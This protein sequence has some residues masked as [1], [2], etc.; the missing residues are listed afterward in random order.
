VKEPSPDTHGK[1]KKGY[2]FNAVTKKLQAFFLSE[3]YSVKSDKEF[4]KSPL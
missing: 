4:L 1:V 3:A 2:Y